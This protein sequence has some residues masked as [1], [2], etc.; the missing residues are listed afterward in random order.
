MGLSI[1]IG[2][3]VLLKLLTIFQTFIFLIVFDLWF[4]LFILFF[5]F[6]CCLFFYCFFFVYCLCFIA[7]HIVCCFWILSFVFACRYFKIYFVYF[8]FSSIFVDWFKKSQCMYGFIKD[9]PILT[10]C[11]PSLSPCEYI[12]PS[13]HTFVGICRYFF[14]TVSFSSSRYH[15]LFMPQKN[16][17]GTIFFGG[18]F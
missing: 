9:K 6:V 14:K 10:Y 7:F 1:F 5:A 4:Y 2:Q 13:F 18:S 3:P 17:S 15:V 8:F 16:A 11:L 12:R